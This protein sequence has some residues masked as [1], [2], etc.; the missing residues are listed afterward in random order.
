MKTMGFNWFGVLPPFAAAIAHVYFAYKETLGWDDGTV[1]F[2]APSWT[3]GVDKKV[4]HAHV[5]WAKRLA[6]NIGAY[7]LL[8]AIGLAWTCVAYAHDDSIARPLAAFFGIW[9]LGA[10]SAALYTRV[11]KAFVAQGVLGLA[12]LA[13]CIWP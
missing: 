3:E 9:L 6:F 4:L 12:L 2:I 13:T 1:Q 8:L 5:T 11:V 7:N 10:A